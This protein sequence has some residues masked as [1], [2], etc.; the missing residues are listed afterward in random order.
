MIRCAMWVAAGVLVGCSAPQVDRDPATSSSSA[1]GGGTAGSGGSG[2]GGESEGLSW[3]PCPVITEGP[4]SDAACA[5]PNVPAY[6]DDPEG[7]EIALFVKRI[8]DGPRQLWMLN[9]GPGASGADFEPIAEYLVSVD[10][11]LSVVLPDHRGTGRSTRL[12]CPEQEAPTS[13]GG[14]AIEEDEWPAC[15]EHVVATHGPILDAFTTTAAAQD[16]GWLV[17]QVRGSGDHVVIWGGS[18]GTRW[19]QRYLHLFG[20]QADGLSMLGITHP[21]LT[22]SDYD[23]RYDAVGALY[24]DAC[25]QDAFCSSKLGP[26]AAQKARDVLEML[27]DGHC[28]ALATAG[29]D[30]SALQSL[31]AYWLLYAWEERAIVPAIVHRI[32]RCAPGDVAALTVLGEALAAPVTPTV[33]DRLQSS[34]LGTHIALSEIWTYPSPTLAELEAIVEQATFSLALGPRFR[35]RLDGWPTYATDEYLGELGPSTRPMLM[36]QGELDPATPADAAAEV[37]A[38]YA[39]ADQHYLEIPGAP[40]NWSSPTTAGTECQLAMV[41]AFALDP[42]AGPYDC[43]DDVL[44]LD[45]VGSSEL[46]NLY[47]G[48]TDLWEDAEASP[49]VANAERRAALADFERWRWRGGW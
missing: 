31:F 6:W 5:T 43:V 24:L 38:F 22:F 41:F 18:Y 39:E 32:E 42:L 35:R 29:I 9:G 15:L 7:P 30:R 17:D 2:A 21:E 47:F 45:F 19:L 46:A 16:V 1:G 4:G 3:S 27:D 20:E 13:S 12:G 14:L 34:V 48:T 40:H 10:P 25:S 49:A 36:L 11:S 26:D 28:P 44:P 8:G 33:Y 23:Q 37:G